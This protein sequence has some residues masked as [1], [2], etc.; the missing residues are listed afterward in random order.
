MNALPATFV[1]FLHPVRGILFTWKFGYNM[2]PTNLSCVK[3]MLSTTPWSM[4]GKK[5][6]IQN[7]AENIFCEIALVNLLKIISK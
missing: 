6:K 5:E 1:T 7:T 2:E 3:L 4:I